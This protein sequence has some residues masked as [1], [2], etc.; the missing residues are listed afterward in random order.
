MNRATV[1]VRS[2]RRRRRL[3]PAQLDR[4]RAIP[5]QRGSCV[6][7]ARELGVS[8]AIVSNIRNGWC[9]TATCPRNALRTVESATPSGPSSPPRQRSTQYINSS[10]RTVDRAALWSGRREGGIARD[11]HWEFTI[12]R[13][14]LSAPAKL[15]WSGLELYSDRIKVAAWV[16]A[17]VL[18]A[19][20]NCDHCPID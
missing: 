12:P 19:A 4:I 9:I 7:L 5:W 17:G 10:G 14:P 16:H 6:A 20:G 2:W 15:R 1:Q 3:T 18:V 11:C 8:V 13:G